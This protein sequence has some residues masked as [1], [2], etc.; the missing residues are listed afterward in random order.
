MVVMTKYRTDT[1]LL[2]SL[3][4]TKIT[5][6]IVS[7]EAFELLVEPRKTVETKS[8]KL[9]VFNGKLYA[10]Y[11]ETSMSK[12]QAE[13]IHHQ[14]GDLLAR[15][16]GFITRYI[17][18][19]MIK[20]IN[21]FLAFHFPSV[22]IKVMSSLEE[23]M[24]DE[25]RFYRLTGAHPEVRA[26][27]SEVAVKIISLAFPVMSHL[28]ENRLNDGFYSFYRLDVSNKPHYRASS[29]KEFLTSEFGVYRKDLA[30]VVL[31]CNDSAVLWASKFVEVLDI[32]TVINALR[33]HPKRSGDDISTVEMLQCL[34]KS[35]I[36]FLLEEGLASQVDSVIIDDALDMVAYVQPEE[37][38][39]CRSWKA[40]HD[41]GIMHYTNEQQ[42]KVISHPAE[43]EEFFE[44]ADFGAMA[45]FPMRDSR[46]YILTGQL[47]NVCV[48]SVAYITR[49][50]EGEAYCFR[51]DED[52]KPYA[53]AEVYA[54]SSGEW[55]IGQVYGQNNSVL[56][57]S[58]HQ[59]LN[60][61]LSKFM[62][63]KQKKVEINA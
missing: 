37:Y 39:L 2:F 9:T 50:F 14:S 44:K 41:F 3:T 28:M 8:L 18:P 31:E 46:S 58:F 52:D 11:F 53:L 36:K 54:T 38:K 49:A 16:P 48:G 24:V 13:R 60:E 51:I 43:F 47:M 45:V 23:S 61:E 22:D 21:D 63:I 40:V 5:E 29:Y 10:R 4:D 1:S 26:K 42:E 20:D 6:N 33:K 19:A 55:A 59:F 35:T 27:V 56:P 34:P 62:S 25:L 57:E 17:H 7:R 30:K 32:D 12:S 15:V